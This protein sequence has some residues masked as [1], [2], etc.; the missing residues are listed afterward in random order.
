MGP[1]SS[2]P[3]RAARRA[4]RRAAR[5]RRVVRR[6]LLA[7]VLATLV[8]GGAVTAGAILRDDEPARERAGA[9]TTT[10]STTTP[11]TTPTTVPP[12]IA[13]PRDPRRGNGQPVTFAFGGDVHF[14]GGLRRKLVADPATVLAPIAP[15]LSAAD[16][17][18]VNLETA[19]TERGVPEDKEYRFRAPPSALTALGA[20][21]V[22]AASM[23]NNHGLDYGRDGLADSLGAK[24]LS[25]SPVVIGIGANAGEA[26]AP[27]RVDVRGQRVTVIAATQVLDGN[28]ATAWAA[29]DTRAGVASAKDR[30]RDR[31]LAAVQ[32]F[33]TDS[34]TLVVFLHWGVEGET[35]PSADQRMIAQ[36]LVNAGADIV[37]GSHSHRLEGAGR[38]GTAFVG[39]GLGNFV[40]Y[41]ETGPAGVS[42]VLQVTATG[43]DIDAYSWVPARIRGG[44]AEPL[45][46]GTEA[47][48]AV[49]DWNAL[50]DCTGL[51]P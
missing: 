17:A 25:A 28:L 3:S 18:V 35:C 48:E 43:R 33:R 20:A 13:P 32:L 8:A 45:P 19:I 11:T 27:Y 14:D 36:Q 16:V 22:D 38:L 2:G 30:W 50:R 29:T 21:G 51:T 7:L 23:A 40:F 44:V 41:N 5:R 49:A 15:A 34:D 37:V 6:S 1:D 42:G 39:Y 26:Y 12:P 47:D 24:A 10:T 9:G 31:L 46:A 4:N